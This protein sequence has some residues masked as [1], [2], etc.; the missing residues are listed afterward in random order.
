M[1]TSSCQK[2]G[3]M[4]ITTH[5]I[6]TDWILNSRVLNFCNVPPPHSGHIIV[7]ALYKCLVHCGIEDKIGTVTIDNA[8]A[9]DVAI[10]TL[11]DS[12]SLR[13]SKP[14]PID[15]Q[16]FHV[17]CCAHIL[18]L[19]VQDGLK[20]I[21]QIVNRIRDGVKYVSSSEGRLIK[22]AEIAKL[23]QLKSK[24][25]IL[26]V[27]TRWNY[28]YYMLH[29]AIQ[30]RDV[31]PRFTVWDRTFSEYVPSNEDWEKVKHVC[32]LL[33]V[34]DGAT[35]ILSGYQYPTSNLFLAELKRVKELIDKKVNDSNLYMRDMAETMKEKFDKY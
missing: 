35:K 17:R 15:G 26:D 16:L 25:L 28:T 22:F 7:D 29:S 33:H 20:P 14:L 31:F 18:N 2:L 23:L 30:F 32:F 4:V 5:W 10:R 1:W 21:T 11:K 34:F 19:C 13:N 12:F 9:N 27:S 8:R 3:Y 6:D 24:K